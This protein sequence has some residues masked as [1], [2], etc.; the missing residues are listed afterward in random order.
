[1]ILLAILNRIISI[2][3]TH[4]GGGKC[5]TGLRCIGT[6]LSQ[7]SAIPGGVP[8]VAAGIGVNLNCRNLGESAMLQ[9]IEEQTLVKQVKV[10]KVSLLPSLSIIFSTCSL[11]DTFCYT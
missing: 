9:H 6:D 3:C 5:I 10:D 2:C 8:T 4:V 11:C 1:M 7:P